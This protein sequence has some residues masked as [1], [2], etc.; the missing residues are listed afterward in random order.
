[1]RSKERSRKIGE[2]S[3]LFM[4]LESRGQTQEVLTSFHLRRSLRRPMELVDVRARQSHTQS[5]PRDTT[6]RSHR[7]VFHLSIRL[8]VSLLTTAC[9]LVTSA[10][11]ERHR[12]QSRFLLR[13]RQPIQRLSGGVLAGLGLTDIRRLDLLDVFRWVCDGRGSREMLLSACCSSGRCIADLRTCGRGGGS[14][15]VCV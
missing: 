8:A 1:M 14:N 15:A 12:L 7:G 13:Q 5:S 4:L 10:A 6:A 3:R 9:S 11:R 2:H